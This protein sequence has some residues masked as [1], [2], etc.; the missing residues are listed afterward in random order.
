V[1]VNVE[2]SKTE[3]QSFSKTTDVHQLASELQEKLPE[4]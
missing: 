2:A 4:E 1:G 3:V